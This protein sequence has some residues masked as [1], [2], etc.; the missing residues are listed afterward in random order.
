MKYRKFSLT[1]ATAKQIS[2]NKRKILHLRKRFNFHRISLGHQHG[3]RFI[4]LGYGG[5]DVT[6]LLYLNCGRKI[7][8]TREWSIE[9]NR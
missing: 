6:N 4:I 8:V 2:Y 3:R 9:R 7:F 1:W 5:R